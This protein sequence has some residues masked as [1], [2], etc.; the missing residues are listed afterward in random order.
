MPV[1]VI[2]VVASFMTTR[3]K[4]R[5]YFARGAT[6]PGTIESYVSSTS[7][8]L[9]TVR[10]PRQKPETRQLRMVVMENGYSTALRKKRALFSSMQTQPKQSDFALCSVENESRSNAIS[11]PNVVIE[12]FDSFTWHR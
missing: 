5:A 12:S 7:F 8:S 2:M 6:D 4:K 9:P 3:T 10:S 1:A 11:L